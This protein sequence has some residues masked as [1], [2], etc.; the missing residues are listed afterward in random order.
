M[1]LK[2]KKE[3]VMKKIL[4]FFAVIALGILMAQDLQS[5]DMSVLVGNLI[6]AVTPLLIWYSAKVSKLAKKIPGIL[7]LTVIALLSGALTFVTNLWTDPGAVWYF[8]LGY[9]LLATFIDQIVRQIKS[10]D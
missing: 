8:Q 1:F 10:G 6:V 9:G 2:I 4:L 3:V 7:M 5:P